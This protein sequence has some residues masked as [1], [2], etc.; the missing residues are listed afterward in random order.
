MHI[1]TAI[2]LAGHNEAGLTIDK[3]TAGEFGIL[4]TLRPDNIGR[5]RLT[6]TMLEKFIIDANKSIRQL[7]QLFG[8]DYERLKAGEKIRIPAEYSGSGNAGSV[9]FYCTARG[10]RRVSLQGIKAEAVAGDLLGLGYER[11]ES[12]E[13]V[14]IV[15]VTEAAK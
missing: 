10:D 8:V 13:L 11:R 5:L 14:L 9:T 2:K 1:N 7:A 15:N 4:K 12:G 6:R 3:V